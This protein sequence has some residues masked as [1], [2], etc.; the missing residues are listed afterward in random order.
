MPLQVTTIITSGRRPA[1]EWLLKVN[2]FVARNT[3]NS[4]AP[5][6]K[7]ASEEIDVEGKAGIVDASVP[8]V[9]GRD[10]AAT[11]GSPL[12]PSPQTYATPDNGS[13]VESE[14]YHRG[15]GSALQNAS[16]S[17]SPATINAVSV[18]DVQ[19]IDKENDLSAEGAAPQQSV[20]FPEPRE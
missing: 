16:G 7:I 1:P 11:T 9:T 18:V 15:S 17:A 4:D 6:E 5:V 8:D 10:F 3:T 13:L 2:R 19:Q 12:S 14:P 20:R